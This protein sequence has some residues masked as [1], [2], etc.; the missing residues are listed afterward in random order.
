[1][2]RAA[3]HS[4]EAEQAVLGAMLLSGDAMV[5]ALD[6]LRAEDFYHDVHRQVFEAMAELSATNTAAD[7]ITLTEALRAKGNLGDV[8]GATYLSQLASSTPTAA[9]LEYHARIVE[10]KS[11][12][13]SLI[14]VSNRLLD[15]GYAGQDEVARLIDEAGEMILDLQGRSVRKSYSSLREILLEFYD[16]LEQ[17]N[18]RGAGITGVASG[19]VDLDSL[20]SG[21]QPSD[22]VVVAARP[23]MGKTAFCLNVAAHAARNGKIPVAFFSLEMSKE[24]LGA[25]LLSLETGIDLMHLRTGRLTSDDWQRVVQ[26]MGQL[27]EVPILIDDTPNLSV[28][29]LRARA[30]RMRLE[31]ELGLVVVDYLQLMRGH[32]KEDGRQQEIA[33]ISRGLKA[34]ARELEV[35]VLALS[36]LS[37]AVEHRQDRRPQLSDLRESGCLAGETLVILAETGERVPLRALAGKTGFAVWALNQDSKCLERV[38]VSRAFSTG[39]RNVFRLETRLG[40]TLRATANHRFLTP[41]G[42]RRLDELGAGH[43]LAL[44]RRVCGSYPQTMSNEEMALLGHLLGGGWAMSGNAVRYTTPK[45]DLALGAAALACQVFGGGIRPRIRRDR[46]RIQVDLLNGPWPV[47]GSGNP[48]RT[49]LEALGIHSLEPGG[50]RIPDKLFQQPPSAIAVFLRHLWLIHGRIR[51]DSCDSA[52]CFATGSPQLAWDVQSLL[53]RLGINAGVSRVARSLK[54][55]GLNHVHLRGG[56]D[57]AFIVRQA[58]AGG[59]GEPSARC[60]AGDVVSGR[61]ENSNWDLV[62]PKTWLKQVQCATMMEPGANRREPYPSMDSWDVPAVLAGRR[63]NRAWTKGYG[64]AIGGGSRPQPAP[65]DIYWDAVVS[66]EPDGEGEVFDLTVP[67]VHNFVA[68][69]IIVHNSIEQDADVVAFIYRDEYYNA[70]TEQPGVAEVIVAKQRNGPTGSVELAF[71]KELGRFRNLEGRYE[72]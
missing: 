37:R 32:G 34:L 6:L 39:V 53:L 35:P 47:R 49:W 17:L 46:H 28:L 43:F 72:E 12:L 27:A 14:R 30:R 65:G 10:E 66:I 64:A 26:G 5:R 44:P 45:R 16:R 50:Q 3:P 52:G 2:E 55:R 29:E 63:E 13:R 21:F 22:L 62:S 61:S 4:L 24:S 38:P 70:E 60:P 59:P 25:R 56:A 31:H 58:G 36:Q 23:S 57:L 33:A 15:R 11:L 48:A 20:T 7:L 41:E 71:Q 68:N 18:S 40:R 19:F 8:G 67:G 51:M 9:N 54:G 1:M 69:D 42:W